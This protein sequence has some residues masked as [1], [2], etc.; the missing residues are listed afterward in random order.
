MKYILDVKLWEK[1]NE[2]TRLIKY[3]ATTF[4]TDSELVDNIDDSGICDPDRDRNF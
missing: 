1:I 4:S 2:G 3:V